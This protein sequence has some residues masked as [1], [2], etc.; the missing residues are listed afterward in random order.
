MSTPSGAGR[1]LALV[2]VAR[3][4]RRAATGRHDDAG[5]VERLIEGHL[6]RRDSAEELG[7]HLAG[8]AP[9]WATTV[10]GPNANVRCEGPG[11][12]QPAREK[13]GASV[14]NPNARA[15]SWAQSLIEAEPVDTSKVGAPATSF[16]SRPRHK[17][18]SRTC[19]PS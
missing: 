14:P 13:N 3:A 18:R 4:R 12:A 15:R 5:E 16:R 7:H 6:P 11:T 8:V 2:L 19:P 17:M 1:R 9:E 10:A